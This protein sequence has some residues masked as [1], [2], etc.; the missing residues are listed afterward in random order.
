MDLR[1]LVFF[2]SFQLWF[3]LPLPKSSLFVYMKLEHTM[4]FTKATSLLATATALLSAWPHLVTAHGE[5]DYDHMGPLGFMWPEDREWNDEA[6]AMTGPCGVS[7]D[8]VNRT[9]FPIGVLSLNDVLYEPVQ[10]QY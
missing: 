8:V 7:G 1:V 6:E 5:D 3:S 2:L 4:A 9:E 10:G